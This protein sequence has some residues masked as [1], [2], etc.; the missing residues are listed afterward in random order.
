MTPAVASPA[1]PNQVGDMDDMSYDADRRIL[2]IAQPFYKRVAVLDVETMTF[3]ETIPMP[4]EPAGID[5]TPS[6]DS[7]LVALWETKSIGVFPLRQPSASPSMV[8]LTVLDTAGRAMPDAIPAPYN[9]RVSATGVAIIMLTY[10]T[11]SGDQVVSLDLRTGAQRIRTDAH[12]TLGIY[13]QS[14]ERTFDRSRIAMMA[15]FCSRIY[16]AASDSFSPCGAALS[17][18]DDAGVTFD[19]AATRATYGALILDSRLQ[20]IR[21]ARS[22]A[23]AMSLDGEFFFEAVE[24]HVRKVRVSDG[25]VVERFLVPLTPRQ[26]YVTPDGKWLLAFDKVF[27]RRVVRVDL[28]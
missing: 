28:R 11:R 20:V 16:T 4:S 6:G 21:I 10:P 18:S 5:L 12:E 27:T 22:G 8:P 2:Y 3:S 19:A 24:Q 15:R 13:Q 9:I 25:I 7:L 14:T 17:G 26:L 23:L 1:A